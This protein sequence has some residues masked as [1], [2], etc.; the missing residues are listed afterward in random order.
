MVHFWCIFFLFPAGSGYLSIP[1]MPAISIEN[2]GTE[3]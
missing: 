1:T 3:D 2:V